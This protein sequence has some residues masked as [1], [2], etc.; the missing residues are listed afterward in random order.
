MK[1]S[2]LGPQ[3]EKDLEMMKEKKNKGKKEPKKE[4]VPDAAAEIDPRNDST[5]EARDVKA[6]QNS[7]ALLKAHALL[8]KGVIQTR[9]P[10]GLFG[11][12]QLVVDV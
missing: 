8:T 5:F 12:Q 11:F 4:K 10:P 7:E 1:L 6:A 3:T 9:F 2:V